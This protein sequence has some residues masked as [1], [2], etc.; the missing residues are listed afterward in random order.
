MTHHQQ[1]SVVNLKKV[2]SNVLGSFILS[3]LYFES[4]Y[5]L[6]SVMCQSCTKTGRELASQ[7]AKNCAI[8]Q[9]VMMYQLAHYELKT[10]DLVYI[11]ST[12]NTV[13]SLSK[14]ALNRKTLMFPVSFCRCLCTIHWR[15][16]LSR[17]WRCNWSS[18][19]R[20]YSNYIWV[21]NNIIAH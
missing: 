2:I 7:W 19:D 13:K 11:L 14:H 21:I 5:G 10:L 16:M 3:Q 20:W 4:D 15:Q 17:E 6:V 9:T 1:S 18:A 8:T 12:N